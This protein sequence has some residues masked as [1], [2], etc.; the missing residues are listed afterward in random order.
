MNRNGALAGI[1]V[2]G[3]DCTLETVHGRLVRCLRNRT[4]RSS[5]RLSLSL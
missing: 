3:V 2:G 5:Y 4:G 1:V